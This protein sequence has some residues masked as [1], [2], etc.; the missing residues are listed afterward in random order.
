ML[1]MNWSYRNFNGNDIFMKIEEQTKVIINLL[2]DLKYYNA[3]QELNRLLAEIEK[4][5]TSLDKRNVCVSCQYSSQG[6]CIATKEIRLE[7]NLNEFM[8]CEVLYQ[9]I[10]NMDHIHDS[11]IEDIEKLS[12]KLS[13]E[14]VLR[15]FT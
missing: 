1:S 15:P 13:S 10:K 5:K 6:D 7:N 4:P 3:K 12:I 11:N 14:D 8:N 9:Y 2:N